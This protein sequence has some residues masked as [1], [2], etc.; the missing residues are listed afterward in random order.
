MYI[1]SAKWSN[2]ILTIEAEEISPV[3]EIEIERIE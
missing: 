2:G 3:H 1:K